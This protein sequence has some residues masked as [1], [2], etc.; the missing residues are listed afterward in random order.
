MDDVTRL[1]EAGVDEG[2]VVIADEQTAGRGRAGRS[3]RAAPGSALLCSI[4]LR[5]SVPPDRLSVLP[6]LTGLAVAE[7]IDDCAPVRCCLKW[8]NDIWIRERKVCGVLMTARSRARTVDFVVLGIGVNL[9]GNPEDIAPGATSIAA[10]SGIVLEPMALL[11]ALLM[12]LQ[13]YY[14][15]YVR[16]GGSFP[17]AQWRERA[18]LIDE[19]VEVG[20]GGKVLTGTFLGVASNGA[21]LLQT[22][23]GMR[24]VVAGDLSRGPIRKV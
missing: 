10:E 21:L 16:L 8:P 1:G 11:E 19:Q 24:H 23:E 13:S 5:P 22:A 7:A 4:L 6:L 14:D 9:I 15:S 12:R 17:V 2:V 20:D 3:W 18:A